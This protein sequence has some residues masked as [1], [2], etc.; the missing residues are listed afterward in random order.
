MITFAFALSGCQT[1]AE[2]AY[3]TRMDNDA[4]R[5]GAQ[6]SQID[7]QACAGRVREVERQAAEARKNR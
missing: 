2:M 1:L 3:D 6:M 5:C 4:R 7:R